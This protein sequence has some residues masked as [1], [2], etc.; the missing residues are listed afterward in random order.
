MNN[1]SIVVASTLPRFDKHNDELL[2]PGC[3]GGYLHQINATVFDRI[4]NSGKCSRV[5]VPCNG[6]PAKIDD[7]V[8]DN[9]GYDDRNGVVIDFRCELCP[10]VSRLS[11]GQ[12]KGRTSVAHKIIAR[13]IQPMEQKR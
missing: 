1:D 6:L 7:D 9:P 5:S 3:G 11:I 13:E 8:Q 2:C 4:G 10:A 12:Y